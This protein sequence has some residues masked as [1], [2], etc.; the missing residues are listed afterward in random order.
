MDADIEDA[1]I[2]PPS[3]ASYLT[4]S[5][6]VTPARAIHGRLGELDS[7]PI[8]PEMVSGRM[9]EIE[10]LS[11]LVAEVIRTRG[12][13]SLERHMDIEAFDDEDEDEDL[14]LDAD[15]EDMDEEAEDSVMEGDSMEL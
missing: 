5:P 2:E 6:D 4:G 9:H 10:A 11:A 1:D 14:D 3:D 12:D 13:G 8:T 15:V 7:D